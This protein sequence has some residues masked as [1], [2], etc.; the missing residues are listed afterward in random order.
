M[1][2]QIIM[3]LHVRRPGQTSGV[4]KAFGSFGLEFSLTAACL[5]AALAPVDTSQGTEA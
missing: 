2:L 4:R 5:S 1:Q 3:T